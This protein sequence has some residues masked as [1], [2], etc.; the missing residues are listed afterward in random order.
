MDPAGLVALKAAVRLPPPRS[1]PSTQAYAHHP[2]PLRTLANESG[3]EWRRGLTLP[4]YALETAAAPPFVLNRH[5][6]R[7]DAER[8]PILPSLFMPGFPKSATS[9]L[10]SCLM[11]V[12]S[13]E[14][15]GCGAEPNAWGSDAC[16]K[17]YLLPVTS[18]MASGQMRLRKEMFFYGGAAGLC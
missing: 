14:H 1:E 6:P 18:S 9:W 2:P 16:K 7:D 17:R 8:A 15:V 3:V 13:P 10:Y 5:M 4:E 12:W 11:A